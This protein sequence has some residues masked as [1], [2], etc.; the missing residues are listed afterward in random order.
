VR[1]HG[2]GIAVARQ[3]HAGAKFVVRP[4]I[5]GLEV[6]DCLGHIHRLR[7]RQR[8]AP[9]AVAGLHPVGGIEPRV[10][11]ARHHAVV[12][13]GGKT[14]RNLRGRCR[15]S[16]VGVF[17]HAVGDRAAARRGRHR[18]PAELEGLD[19]VR[20]RERGDGR[21]RDGR[22][23]RW[24]IH[25]AGDADLCHVGHGQARSTAHTAALACTGV[26]HRDG[27]AHAREHRL[28]KAEGPIAAHGDGVCVGV[29][30]QG[31]HASVAADGARKTE[32][33]GGAAHR[34]GGQRGVGIGHALAACHGTRLAL[35]LGAHGDG[36]GT[37]HR[38]GEREAAIGRHTGFLGRRS[39]RQLQHQ[40]LARA[41]ARD[42]TT[43]GACVCRD[44]T[45]Q[46]GHADVVD[47]GRHGARGVG[48]RAGLARRLALDAQA[49]DRTGGQAHAVRTVGRDSCIHPAGIGND[50]R[51]AHAQACQ[52][53]AHAVGDGRWRIG[54]ACAMSPA[55]GR[56]RQ[57]CAEQ[58][59]ASQDPCGVWRWRA[60]CCLAHTDVPP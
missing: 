15:A 21:N 25:H 45:V 38:L 55:A 34:N 57:R 26:K 58:P 39:Y 40:A 28:R 4:G 54:T 14:R 36:I 48:E 16:T 1:P 52:L 19:V 56:Q 9:R 5:A 17:C 20:Q 29:V 10:Q 6:P 23:W 24:R 31:H 46:A 2:Q 44:V 32:S 35:R 59:S 22:G 60:C 12:A 37:G 50:H 13:G 30:A 3:C 33:V 53:A 11:E 42:R 47:I 51:L 43:H 7:G 49:V 41:Q 8:T 18:C 27:I